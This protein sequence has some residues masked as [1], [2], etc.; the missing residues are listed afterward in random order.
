MSDRYHVDDFKNGYGG[1]YKKLLDEVIAECL[2]LKSG[3]F[4]K[5]ISDV[6]Q[7]PGDGFKTSKKIAA[8]LRQR[9][10]PVSV[11]ACLELND[12]VGLTVV[13]QYTD[14][15]D[16]VL[17]ALK[18]ALKKNRGIS[19]SKPERHDNKAGYYATHV[20]CERMAGSDKLKCEIQVKTVLHDAWASKMH[21]LTYKPAG[22]LDPRL[23]QLMASI[24]VTLENLEHQSVTIRDL[25]EASWDVEADARQA[26]RVQFFDNML[27]YRKQLWRDSLDSEMSALYVALEEKT[28]YFAKA[29]DG[30]S[31]LQKLMTAIEKCCADPARIRQAW[32]ISGRIAMIRNTPEVIRS[33]SKNADQWLLQAST[34]LSEIN[35][36]EIS[37][38]PLMFYVLGDIDLA[39][40]YSGSIKSSSWFSELPEAVRLQIEFNEATFLT[41]REY[42]SPTKEKHRRALRGQ[43]E[44]VLKRQWAV[45]TP[46]ERSSIADTMG[47]VKITFGETKDEVKAGIEECISASQAAADEEKSVSAAYV[48]LNMRL[49]WRRYFELESIRKH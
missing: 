38:V 34:A 37:A 4:R 24:A 18:L 48:D 12:I 26:A 45:A 40:E 29:K 5:Q 8:K 42:H 35:A 31:K 39:V 15:V 28:D 49:G 32:I 16:A 11:K 44:D 27:E 43:I 23:S 14:Q 17:K 47:L 46:D 6:Y 33:F 22:V 3:K 30:D 41:E 9:G 2:S 19:M 13:I 7:R 1:D 21:D 10:K 36:K 25:I 20:I